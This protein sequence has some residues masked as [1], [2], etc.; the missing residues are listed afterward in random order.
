MEQVQQV[1]TYKLS[2]KLDQWFYTIDK[3]RWNLNNSQTDLAK[4]VLMEIQSMMIKRLV[5]KD[6]TT[7]N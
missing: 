1:N 4:A 3:A 2:I 7:L 6:R 5:Y